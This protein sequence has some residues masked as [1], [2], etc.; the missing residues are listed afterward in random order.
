MRRHRRNRR[1]GGLVTSV[2]PAPG[3]ATPPL[4]L[5]TEIEQTIECRDNLEAALPIL[6]ARRGQ[7]Q[8]ALLRSLAGELSV[9]PMDLNGALTKYE[10]W[11]TREARADKQLEALNQLRT[12]FRKRAERLKADAPAEVGHALPIL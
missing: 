11:T 10:V 8:S 5:T 2:A 1:G 3:T 9:S 7:E 4:D 12:M 6:A